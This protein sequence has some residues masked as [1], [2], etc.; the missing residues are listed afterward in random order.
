MNTAAVPEGR[1]SIADTAKTLGL[2]EALVSFLPPAREEGLQGVT[3]ESVALKPTW[4]AAPALTA[5]V[6]CCLLHL[7]DGE[8]SA[9]I[10]EQV[11]VGVTSATY[12]F[13]F[14][15]SFLREC[16]GGGCVD[17]LLVLH[18]SHRKYKR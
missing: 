6:G 9:Q 7:M 3:R 12:R 16:L 14:C 5:N 17:L 4:S 13:C 15:F 18:Q 2:A 8:C 10:T 1:G 11:V